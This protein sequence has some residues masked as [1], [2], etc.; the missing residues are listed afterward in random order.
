MMILSD[1]M[2]ATRCNANYYAIYI[3]IYMWIYVSG[4]CIALFIKYNNNNNNSFAA[5]TEAPFWNLVPQRRP[6]YLRKGTIVIYL[7]E[8]VILY[9]NNMQHRA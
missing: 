2:H 5:H 3:E 8:I 6:R 7:C 1:Q 4:I 9:I